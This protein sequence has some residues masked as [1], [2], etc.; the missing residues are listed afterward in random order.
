MKAPFERYTNFGV[1]ASHFLQSIDSEVM[2]LIAICDDQLSQVVS[3]DVIVDEVR[4]DALRAVREARDAVQSD[5]SLDRGARDYALRHLDMAEQ[6]LVEYQ[7]FGIKRAVEGAETIIG[8]AAV[9]SK[10]GRVADESESGS[11]VV[12][13]LKL[14]VLCITTAQSA[15]WLLETGKDFVKWLN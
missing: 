2:A 4:T 13:A 15:Q 3:E 10:G 5:E 12:D 6:A 8:M 1:Q 11:K 14:T 7:I 9:A